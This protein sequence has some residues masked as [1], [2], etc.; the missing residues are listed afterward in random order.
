MKSPELKFEI[1]G[2]N[3][4][5]TSYEEVV[6]KV[7]R[8]IADRA[9]RYI[10]VCPVNNVM[11]ARSDPDYRRILNNAAVATPDGM[12]VV[13]FM[14]ISGNRKQERV[15]G[16]VLMLKLCEAA[17]RQG[18]GIF[19]YGG[20]G[21][22][23]EKLEKNLV[24]LFPCLRIAGRIAPPFRPLT[25][26]EDAEI[27]RQIRES[28]AGIVFVGLGTPKQEQWMADHVGRL[29][30]V[31]V[32]VGAAFDF[33]AGAVRQAPV[34]LQRLGFE[35]AF[36]LLMEPRRLFWRYVLQNPRFAALSLL[37]MFGIRLRP[38]ERRK[39]RGAE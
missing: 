19:L 38:R 20:T 12:P 7:S 16:P 26:E 6:E 8:W 2:T 30:A 22:V 9:P 37:H 25:S 27:V 35:W 3:I 23:L 34:I 28:G 39:K 10:C 33:H 36:R 18:R 14:R 4:S 32:G 15:Y 24:G 29:G 11:I 5:T 13:W 21:D 1:L 17:V 31:L